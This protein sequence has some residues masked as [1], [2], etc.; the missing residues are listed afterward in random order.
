MPHVPSNTTASVAILTASDTR[1]LEEDKSGEIIAQK[2]LEQGHTV[3][4]RV[5]LRDEPNH[6]VAKITEWIQLPSVEVIIVTGG[7]GASA[8]DITP[9]VLLPMFDATLPGF[10][11]LFR[12]LSYREI[13]AGAMLSRAE[14][15]W[16]DV[17]GTRKVLF[18][19]PGSPKA[20]SLA[21]E[22]LILPQLGHL[23][24]ICRLEHSQ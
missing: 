1:T 24:D 21:L 3:V 13:G 6:I 7:T 22:K 14:A 20:V 15:G 16:I 19:L 18:L 10:G 4:E 8:R 23:L 5:I 12:Q 9:D 17:R 2:L 11:E